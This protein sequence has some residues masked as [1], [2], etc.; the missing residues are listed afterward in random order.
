M[1]AGAAALIGPWLKLLRISNLP[2]VWANVLS[3]YVAGAVAL[4]VPPAL[5]GLLQQTWLLALGFGAIYLGGMAMNDAADAERDRTEKPTRPIARGVITE[6]QA[7]T[8]AATLLGAGLGFL[9]V[10]RELVSETR[11]WWPVLGGVVLVGLVAIYNLVHHRTAASILLLAACRA[12]V[13]LSCAAAT[14]WTLG[15]WQP[16]ALAGA[17]AAYILLLSAIARSEDRGGEGAAWKRRV[18]I[19]MLAGLPLVDAAFLLAL[20]QVSAALL[21]IVCMG[22]SGAAQRVVS[23]T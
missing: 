2:T 22:L 16:W 1:G 12:M 17:I 10:F 3:G 4:G 23:G 20:G 14:A 8:A 13:V 11:A 21:C 15:A 5:P 9:L 18:V 19:G 7:W 6:A